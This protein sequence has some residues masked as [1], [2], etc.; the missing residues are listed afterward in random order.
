MNPIIGFKI[1]NT[2]LVKSVYAG[3]VTLS[4]GLEEI[5]VTYILYSIARL[6]FLSNPAIFAF[7]LADA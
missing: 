7:F 6:A 5:E 2:F 3:L 4:P 1:V